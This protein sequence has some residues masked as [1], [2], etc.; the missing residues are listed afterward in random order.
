MLFVDVRC[1]L[2]VVCR[3][4]FMFNDVFACDW[5]VLPFFLL[6]CAVRRLLMFVVRCSLVWVCCVL[7]V[8]RCVVCVVIS[9]LVCCVFCV[10]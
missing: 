9:V 6:P 5:C 1:L 10:V 2:L 3:L 7:F 8:V 4:L